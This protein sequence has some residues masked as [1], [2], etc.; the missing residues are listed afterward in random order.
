MVGAFGKLDVAAADGLA[1]C[2]QID[3]SFRGGRR[4]DD[5]FDWKTLPAEY[6]TGNGNG[7]QPQ[8]GFG[9]SGQGD[10]VDGYAELL[11]LPDGARSAA[12][13]FIAIGDQ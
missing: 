10:G 5:Y 9:A 7:F 1:F 4:F 12:Q 13:V 3:G 11:C 6:L 2:R 8:A